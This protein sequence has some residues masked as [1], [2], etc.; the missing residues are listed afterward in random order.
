M[1]DPNADLFRFIA[2]H[3]A[4]MVLVID[5]EG[6]IVYANRQFTATSGYSLDELYGQSPV[7]FR[8][9]LTP[10]ETIREMWDTITAGDTWR[11]EMINVARNGS[12]LFIDA[13]VVPFR[14]ADGEITH[15][16]G[17]YD[18]LADRRRVENALSE[19][20]AMLRSILDHIP[21]S[22]FWKDRE[23]RFLGCNQALAEEAGLSSPNDIIGRLDTEL[24]WADQANL[25]QADDRAVMESGIPRLNFEEPQTR[26]DGSLYVLRTSK[27]P[28]RNAA[29]EI[30]GVL[31]MYEDI[32]ERKETEN[33]LRESEIRTRAMLSA[34][35]D[36]LL[37]IQRD[38]IVLD[39]M[40][41]Q[42]ITLVKPP[43][44][45]IG[46]PFEDFI[47]PEASQRILDAVG[48][49]LDHGTHET[50][51][52]VG[53]QRNFEVRVIRYA[54]NIA[55]VM[56][57][58]QT[59]RRHAEQAAL[60]LAAERQRVAVIATFVSK[61]S[62][63]FRTPLSL[64]SARAYT[65]LQTDDPA[66][67]E[68]DAR[69]IRDQVQR[70]A[71]LVND[72][73]MMARLDAVTTVERSPLDLTVIVNALVMQAQAE[74][75]RQNL[76][77]T[78]HTCPEPLRIAGHS[79]YM[80][81]AVQN[82]IENALRYTAPPGTVRVHLAHDDGDAVLTVRDSGPGIEREHLPRIFERFFR[83]DTAHSTPGFGLGLPMARRIVQL[84]LGTLNVESTPETGS[85]FTIRV[86]LVG[87]ND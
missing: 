68:S 12:L 62:H 78:Q 70:L 26:A 38:G 42:S 73:I 37:Q 17:F 76:T 64:I 66:R 14:N 57:R 15:F 22:I 69:Q 1:L 21:W 34:I 18:D 85:A 87:E 55:L 49:V 9:D 23:S 83:A 7:I 13:T 79:E 28:L 20:Q 86:P 77:L 63:E 35:P 44:E 53:R 72:L 24:A 50:L 84:H 2:D 60:D 58:D 52:F 40:P 39:L 5:V 48:T 31:G 61:A 71:R 36:M 25:Y 59:A 82:V 81:R 47:T 75:E 32:T 67:R 43:Q 29:G 33:A 8:S 16:V 19:S 27:V 3:S 10:P 6:Q 51:E 11:G 65:I 54:P 45:V 74:A 80:S 56:V 46:K 4:N 30:V 41:G